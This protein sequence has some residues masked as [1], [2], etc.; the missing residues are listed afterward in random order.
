MVSLV[1]SLTSY[2]LCVYFLAM[3]TYLEKHQPVKNVARFYRMAVLPNLFGEWTLCR[4]W[5]RIGYGGQTRMDW[6]VDKEQ[7]VAALVALEASK[8]Q[9]GYWMRPQQL[10]M[11]DLTR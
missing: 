5:G 6:F 8:R 3:Q 4:E 10:A 9:R 11:F 1:Y 7:A 2:P